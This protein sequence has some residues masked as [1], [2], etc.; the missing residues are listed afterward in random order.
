MASIQMT[1]F[2]WDQAYRMPSAIVCDLE[3]TQGLSE[4]FAQQI[5]G[6]SGVCMRPFKSHVH[7]GCLNRQSS[8]LCRKLTRDQMR[9]IKLKA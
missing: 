5:I 4:Y 6:V 8:Y 1:G 9:V 3:N 2:S 7:R